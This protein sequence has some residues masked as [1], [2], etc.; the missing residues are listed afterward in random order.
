[1]QPTAPRALTALE[2][3]LDGLRAH[4]ALGRPVRLYF[5]HRDQV[6]YL[7][8]GG[9]NTLFGY[10]V[11]ALLQFLLGGFLHYLVIVL[12]AWPIAVL[13][14]YLCYRQIVFRSRGSV[15]REFPRFS[16]VYLVTLIVNLAVLPFALGALPFNIYVVQALF[17]TVVIVCS[18]LAHKYYSFRGGRHRDSA[19]PFPYDPP[20][21]PRG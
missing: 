2:R 18:Y 13:N 16:L 7:A 4:P 14:A 8:V 9:W 19:A 6:F 3:H 21:E 20:A 11:W 5:G 15:L 10:A 1:M 17:A 12:L